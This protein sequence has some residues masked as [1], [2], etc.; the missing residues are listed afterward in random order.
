MKKDSKLMISKA[1]ALFRLSVLLLF[2][3]SASAIYAQTGIIKGTI[4]DAK[5]KEPLL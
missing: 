2:F 5:T 3:V 4:V 1:N